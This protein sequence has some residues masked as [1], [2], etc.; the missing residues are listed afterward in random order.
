MPVVIQTDPT[1]Y[2]TLESFSKAKAFNRW[3]YDSIKNDLRGDILELGSGIGNISGLLLTDHGRVALSDLRPEYCAHLDRLYHAD[4][5]LSGVYELD[6]S[7]PDFESCHPSLLGKFDTVIALNVIEHIS[8]DGLTIRN[9]RALLQNGGRLIVLVPSGQWLYNNL[10]RELGH[11]R[12]YSKKGLKDLIEQA[13][14]TVTRTRYFNAAAIAGWWLEGNVLRKKII[15]PFS[16]HLYDQMVP[17][18]K[19]ADWFITP[20]TGISLIAVATKN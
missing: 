14:L 17:V 11:V 6:L 8:D 7:R 15:S 1:G 19:F 3:Q 5:H 9:A 18:F 13:G 20:F 16:L 12:R 10:D 4:P 2:E